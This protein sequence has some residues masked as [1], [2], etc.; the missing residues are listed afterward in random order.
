M[1]P[2]YSPQPSEARVVRGSGGLGVEQFPPIRDGLRWDGRDR[3]RVDGE[4]AGKGARKTL[5]GSEAALLKPKNG[6]SGPPANP[7]MV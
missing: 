5:F 4:K 7:P 6:L 3:M 1:A 2:V